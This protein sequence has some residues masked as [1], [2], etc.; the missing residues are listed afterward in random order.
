[1]GARIRIYHPETPPTWLD[2]ALD[3]YSGHLVPPRLAG[4]DYG[5]VQ[6]SVTGALRELLD[7]IDSLHLS[8]GDVVRVDSRF[9][10]PEASTSRL[11]LCI[12]LVRRLRFG[13]VEVNGRRAPVPIRWIEFGELPR[14]TLL[15][16]RLALRPDPGL[17][18][19]LSANLGDDAEWED[20][21]VAGD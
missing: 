18:S 9:R 15:L 21:A 17:R 3:L 20:Y 5:L 11:N 16:L 7:G 4:V 14:G 13:Q 10:L 2:R 1:M 12:E 19:F 8:G 6:R